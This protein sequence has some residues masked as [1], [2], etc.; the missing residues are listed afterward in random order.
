MKYSL[1]MES[2]TYM[3]NEGAIF[4]SNERMFESYRPFGIVN[5]VYY[6]DSYIKAI[7]Q[8]LDFRSNFENTLADS[9]L[10]RA[11]SLDGMG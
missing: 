10:L 3:N 2:I 8:K 9:I 4:R 5:A 7:C 11:S 6:L 1:N